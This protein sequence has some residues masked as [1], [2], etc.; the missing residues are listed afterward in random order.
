MTDPQAQTRIGILISNLGTPDAPTPAALRKYLAEFLSDPY[1]IDKPRWLWWFILHGVILRLRPGRAA[2]SYQKIWTSE[3]SP[4]LEISKKQVRALQAK[5]A[6]RFNYPVRVV[7]AMR[8]GNPSIQ[9]GINEL[10]EFGATQLIVLPLYPQYSR[11][12]TKSTFVAVESELEGS[13]LGSNIYS[14]NNYHEEGDYINTVAESINAYWKK[15]GKSQHLLFSFH[16]LPQRYADNGDPYAEQCQRTAELIAAKLE[17]DGNEWRLTF[18]SRFG[19]DP[20][21]QPYTDKTLIALAEEGTKSVD[22]ITPGFP[23]DCLETLEE[24]AI[25]NRDIFLNAGGDTYNYIPCLN[26]DPNHI[27]MMANLITRHYQA[28]I[29]K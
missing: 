4:L 5:L 17:L 19:P 3:G 21:L 2:K 27:E 26:E 1:V 12:T 14:I 11:T 24:I 10:K 18:Q 25:E 13:S 15:N 29:E 6:P 7:L 28:W 23:A 22:I 20:W 8:Y 9:Q 16:G